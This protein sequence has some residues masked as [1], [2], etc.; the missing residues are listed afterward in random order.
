MKGYLNLDVNLKNPLKM[1]DLPSE[2]EVIDPEVVT[3][4]KEALN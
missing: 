1:T 3:P 4:K 2:I